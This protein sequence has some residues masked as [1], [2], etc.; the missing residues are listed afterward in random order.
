MSGGSRSEIEGV[1]EYLTINSSGGA[2]AELNVSESLE[3]YGSGGTSV[4]KAD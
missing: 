4:H 1:V 2:F 3:V